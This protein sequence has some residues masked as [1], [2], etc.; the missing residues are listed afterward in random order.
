VIFDNQ[1]EEYFFISKDKYGDK[2]ID[3]LDSSNT[4]NYSNEITFTNRSYNYCIGIISIV[5]L[6]QE[7]TELDNAVEIRKY[8]S[9]FYNTMASIIRHYGGKV[10]KNVGDM[11]LFYFPKTVN[12]S[13]LSTFQNV[14]ECGLEMVKANMMLN[15]KLSEN[16]LPSISYKISLNY[17]K[18]ELAISSNSNTVDLFGPA[19]N[20]CS[21]INNLSLPYQ[22]VIYKALYDIIEKLSF[23]KDYVFENL[24]EN[25]I[26]GKEE[27]NYSHLVYS[28][29]RKKDGSI[30]LKKT[31]D[32]KED[33]FNKGEYPQNQNNSSF[34][35]LLIDDDKDIL[36]TFEPFIR[37]EGYNLISHS[38]PKE[39]L[40]HLSN[41]DPY[42]YD[43]IIL[44]IRMPR[45]NGFQLYK[46]IKILN[47]DTK[48]LFLTALDVV[49]EIEFVCPGMKES[50]ILRKP[51]HPDVLLA[52]IE[53]ALYS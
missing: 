48:V 40:D 17:G 13:Q 24:K 14:L 36:F 51:V 4:K 12:F 15:S 35:I 11:I 6:S 16:G 37:G 7:I 22:I 38:D 5:N 50:D 26:D 2:K 39:A 42:Y 47:P 21:K 25:G 3:N 29:K 8:Y 43:L 52:K 1:D 44:D 32:I 28:V 46:Q 19:V 9:L 53:L 30:F 23:F 45:F 27:D 18:V 41:L 49:K 20:I 34:N 33:R 31:E 10:I